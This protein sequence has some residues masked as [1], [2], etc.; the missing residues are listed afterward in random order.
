MRVIPRLDLTE[1]H[2]RH[3]MWNI[4]TERAT[5]TYGISFKDREVVGTTNTYDI[6]RNGILRPLVQLWPISPRLG[7]LLELVCPDT[8]IK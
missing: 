8:I 2:V 7:G 3:L 4:E 5:L 1:R 6:P